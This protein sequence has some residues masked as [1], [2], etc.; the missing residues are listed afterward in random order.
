MQDRSSTLLHFYFS[1][2]NLSVLQTSTYKNY[3]SDNKLLT[4]VRKLQIAVI[5]YNKDRCTDIASKIAYEVGKEIARAGAVLI[6]GGLG[7]VM[8]SACKGAK[9]S[10][11][12]TVGVIPQEEFSYANEYCD[13]V[14][15]TGMGYARDFI[16][17]SSADGIIAVGGGIGTLIELGVGYMTNKTMVAIAGS[18]GIADIYGGKFLDERNRVPITV[19]KDAKAA[20]KVILATSLKAR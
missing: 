20:V 19:V 6:C 2:F 10:G 5:G 7:G 4:L 15:C 12:M 8:E 3:N 9:E 1:L 17:A 16:V 13:I 11:G 14:V 18:G